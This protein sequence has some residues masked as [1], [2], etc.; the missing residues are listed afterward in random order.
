MA[1][2]GTK[3]IYRH[4]YSERRTGFW[5]YFLEKEILPNGKVLKYHYF[6]D[7]LARIE[8]LDPREQTVY[9]SIHIKGL[10]SAWGRSFVASSG[11]E[12]KHRYTVRTSI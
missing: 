5:V 9:A 12:V 4:G 11:S 3:R 8:S 10:N 7:A 6:G 2:D 1:A